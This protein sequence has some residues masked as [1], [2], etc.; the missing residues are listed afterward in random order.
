[1]TR[2]ILSAACALTF[3]CSGTV[4]APA[5]T[6]A[7]ACGGGVVRSDAELERY[8]GCGEVSGDLAVRGVTSL[9]PLVSL[10]R[11]TGTLS[12]GE[13]R[14]LYTLDGLEELRSVGT[15]E[16]RGN[17][18][19]IHAGA[20][21]NLEDAGHATLTDNPRLSSTFGLLDGIERA[22][23]TIEF[24]GNWGLIAEGVIE[25]RRDGAVAV[26]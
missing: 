9:A 4:S 11:V 21:G 15:L 12:I 5:R 7:V 2:F 23:V 3:A 14:R 26:R 24:S 22:G 1:M 25:S 18:G 10:R 6:Q 19:L 13:T 17:A 16:L 8:R 20:L